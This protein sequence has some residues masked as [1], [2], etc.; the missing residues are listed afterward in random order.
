MPHTRSIC[1]F[2]VIVAGA[3]AFRNYG[4]LRDALDHLLR[5]PLPDVVILTRSGAGLGTDSLALSYALARRLDVTQYRA[6]HAKHPGLFD[7]DQARNAELVRDADA[8]VLV[9]DAADRA[10]R[11]LLVRCKAR[12]I[13]VRVPGVRTAGGDDPPPENPARRV[14][15]D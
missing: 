13:P 5:D 7:A 4:L 9:W 15:L 6:D 11:D 3:A 10:V 2:R 1:T 8:A 12:G 14:L